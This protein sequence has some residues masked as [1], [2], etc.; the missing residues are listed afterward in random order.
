MQLEKIIDVRMYAVPVHYM[1][2][3]NVTFLDNV[4]KRDAGAVFVRS[5]ARPEDSSRLGISP[6]GISLLTP[7]GRRNNEDVAFFQ[8]STFVGNKCRRYGGAL[9]VLSTTVGCSRCEFVNNSVTIKSISFGGAVAAQVL[10]TFHGRGLVMS[11]NKA[12]HGGGIGCLYAI[13]DIVNATI[14]G[15]YA[16]QRGGGV[17]IQFRATQ[18]FD[19]ALASR[20]EQCIIRNNTSKVAGGLLL[21]VVGADV[22]RSPHKEIFQQ[23]FLVVA[24][25]QLIGNAAKITGGAVYTNAPDYMAVLCDQPL[26]KREVVRSVGGQKWL[27]VADVVVPRQ[28]SLFGGSGACAKIWADN[29]VEKQGRGGPVATSGT[30]ARVCGSRSGSC[31]VSSRRCKRSPRKCDGEG[32]SLAI[33]NHTSG[34]LLD[35]FGVEVFDLFNRPALQESGLKITMGT[36]RNVLVTGQVSAPL[37]TVTNITELRFQAKLNRTYDMFVNFRRAFIPPV[38][39]RVQVR[40]CLPGEVPNKNEDLCVACGEDMYSFSPEQGCGACPEN[41]RCGASTVTPEAGYWQATSVSAR[42]HL[43]TS[44]PACDYEDRGSILAARARQAHSGGGFLGFEDGEYQQCSQGYGGVLCGTCTSSYGKV[45]SGECIDCG[46]RRKNITLAC[47]C[48]IWYAIIVFAV[49]RSTLPAE[50]GNAALAQGRPM[51]TANTN[52]MFHGNNLTA[53]ME[54]STSTSTGYDTSIELQS[55]GGSMRSPVRIDTG[56]EKCGARTEGS[57]CVDQRNFAGDIFK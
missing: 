33:A 21:L 30:S 10:G 23:F 28:S 26:E 35:A 9:F 6:D 3:T 8:D 12:P 32:L 52:P 40:G 43:C 24:Q 4:A 13:C 19:F 56:R 29:T 50:R 7:D 15:N 11:G 42:M 2:G 51:L 44:K 55:M 36:G 46:N 38:L 5:L 45:R 48:G 54:T 57:P 27:E 31:A 1:N 14:E 22:A 41:A 37:R 34:E 53:R 47:L 17:A 49:A 16:S 25:S 18:L 20:L 39:L